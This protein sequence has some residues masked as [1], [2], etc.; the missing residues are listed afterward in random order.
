MKNLLCLPTILLIHAAALACGGYLDMFASEAVDSDPA[1]RAAAVAALRDAGPEGLAVLLETHADWIR[2]YDAG[3]AFSG[4]DAAVWQRVT[5]ALDAVSRQKDCHASK[6]YWFTDLDAAR[7]AAQAA[8]KPIL[9]LRLLGNLDDELSCANSRFFRTVLYANAEVSRVLRE[10]FILHWSSERPVPVVTIDFG[11]GRTLQRTIT[12]NSVHYVL[13]PAGN[14]L[15]AIPGLI[16][17]PI[18]L[19]EIARS[20]E[21]VASG[22]DSASPGR[23]AWHRLDR[24]H[25]AEAERL[26]AE[27]ERALSILDSEQAGASAADRN[28]MRIAFAEFVAAPHALKAA[29]IA[30][31]K[32]MVELPTLAALAPRIEALENRTDHAVWE[33]VAALYLDASRLDESSR[34]LMRT[35]CSAGEPFERVVAR[36]ERSIAADTAYNQLVLHRRIHERLGTATET[37]PLTMSAL[38]EWVYRE[39]FL[40]PRTDPWLGLL[41]EATYAALPQ[42]GVT[43]AR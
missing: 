7:S 13:D 31:S 42:G 34:R 27:W 10:R 16:A 14:V 43:S 12:G 37:G 18:F 33:R 19:A 5:A 4:D 40:T 24:G 8:R 28:R 15:D 36:F 9:S 22:G 20:A 11:D 32:R 26:T 1:R 41:P 17:P 23:I 2:R 30:V 38:N 39:L 21:S 35:K 3:E 25:V 29:P 6:L